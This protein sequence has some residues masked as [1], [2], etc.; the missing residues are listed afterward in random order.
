MRGLGPG[1]ITEPVTVTPYLGEGPFGP[2]FAAAVT[3]RCSFDGTRRLVRSATGDE[4]VAESTLRLSD[5]TDPAVDIVAAF[6]PESKVT[7]AGRDVKVITAKR[8]LNRGRLAYL[9]VSTT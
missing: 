7:V 2:V 3:T 8:V 5:R 4:V 1:Q 9:E 6:T